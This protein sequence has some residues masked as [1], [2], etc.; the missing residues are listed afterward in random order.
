MVRCTHTILCNKVCLWVS[1]VFSTNQ[2]DHD[3][4]EI[5]LKVALKTINQIK[6]SSVIQILHIFK[7]SFLY[8]FQR[9]KTLTNDHSIMGTAK[10]TKQKN[11]TT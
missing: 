1:L 9:F 6:P 5:L 7:F 3:I 4:T 8:L 10:K 11:K 2:I